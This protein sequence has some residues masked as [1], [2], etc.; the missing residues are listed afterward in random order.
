MR[1]F[2]LSYGAVG[3]CVAGGEVRFPSKQQLR[4]NKP[5]ED[6]TSTSDFLINV[7]IE[8]LPFADLSV[9]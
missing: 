6:G 3:V 8:S 2:V 5:G 9:C 4:L 7:V 1:M